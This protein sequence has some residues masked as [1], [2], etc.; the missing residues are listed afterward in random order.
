MSVRSVYCNKGKG[1]ARLP[2]TSS[3]TS[4]G[5]SRLP[6]VR[7][8]S[9][10]WSLDTKSGSVMPSIQATARLVW[11]T[12]PATVCS[13]RRAGFRRWRRRRPVCKSDSSRKSQQFISCRFHKP[14]SSSCSFDPQNF[15]SL[16]PLIF[17]DFLCGCQIRTS[18]VPR[19]V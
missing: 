12:D 1:V 13:K 11:V 4:A 10:L 17:L 5:V 18:F 8:C 3:S 14:Q 6:A 16:K 15:Q 2:V 19:D 7:D 9:R